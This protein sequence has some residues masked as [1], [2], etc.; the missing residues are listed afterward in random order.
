MQVNDKIMENF[1]ILE[2]MLNIFTNFEEEKSIYFTEK[3]A[4][5]AFRERTTNLIR[6]EITFDHPVSCN[7]ENR[8]KSYHIFKSLFLL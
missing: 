1:S 8:L 3:S 4:K 2:I 5:C 6:K 7:T